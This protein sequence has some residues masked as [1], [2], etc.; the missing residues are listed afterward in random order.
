[1]TWT[2]RRAA[3]LAVD[4]FAAASAIAGGLA[5]ML[6]WIQFPQEWLSSSAFS[7]LISD[8][9]VAG[10]I[11][12]VVVGGSALAAAAGMFVGTEAGAGLSF[13]A[14]LVMMGWIVAEIG[15]IAQLSWLQ[16]LYFATGMAMV[17]LAR[18]FA[19]ERRPIDL[20]VPGPLAFGDVP[21]PR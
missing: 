11:L 20:R 18:A 13:A 3:L 14:G 17:L 16:V 21:R 19:R 2:E 7:W 10:A 12:L 4:L 15:I 1:M 9:F 8:Y 6:G 5:V